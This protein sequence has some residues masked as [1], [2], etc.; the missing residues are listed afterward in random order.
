VSLQNY[1]T[2]KMIRDQREKK[3]EVNNDH[4]QQEPTVLAKPIQEPQQLHKTGSH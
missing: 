2:P 4:S 3:K 1:D